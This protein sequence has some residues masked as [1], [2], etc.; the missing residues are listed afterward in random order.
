MSKL[1]HTTAESSEAI[2]AACVRVKKVDK[3]KN[4]F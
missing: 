1:E 2:S 3:L 4:I